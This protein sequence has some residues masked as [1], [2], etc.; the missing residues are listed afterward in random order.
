VGDPYGSGVGTSPGGIKITGRLSAAERTAVDALVGA[1]AAEDGVRALDERAT[2]LL[3]VPDATR[4]LLALGGDGTGN[5]DVVGYA[6]LDLPAV[7]AGGPADD[8]PAQ[9]ATADLVV[10]PDRRGRGIGR[11]LADALVAEAGSVPVQVWAHGPHP[12]AARLAAATGFTADRALAWMRRPLHGPDARPLPDVTPPA[13]ITIRT[14]EPG[15]DEQAWLA[16]N[17]AAFAAHPEQGRWTR[18]DLDARIAADWFDPAGFFVAERD[19]ELVGFHWTKVHTG[20]VRGGEPGPAGEIYVL[21]V[22]PHAQG[23]GLAKALAVAGLAYLR[24]RGLPTVMLYVEDGNRAAVGLYEKLGFARAATDVM[25]HH[26]PV[27]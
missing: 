13:G 8:D 16:V 22:A 7:T 11:A 9:A 18:A 23:G 15:R 10:R 21:G 1:A 25:Y 27:G 14:F 19:G 20:R 12:G 5:G 2:L 26:E 17:A 4:H 24:D 6:H 3:G